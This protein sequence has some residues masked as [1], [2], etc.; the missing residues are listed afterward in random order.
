VGDLNVDGWERP[1]HGGAIE[2]GRSLTT[3]AQGAWEGTY[4]GV[5]DSVS[6]DT[7]VGWWTGSGAYV[8][9]SFFL[10]GTG[11]PPNTIQGLIYPGTPPQP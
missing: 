3:N 5:F 4:T 10:L 11:Y 7:Y 8:G 2:W 6:G 1:E 9:L